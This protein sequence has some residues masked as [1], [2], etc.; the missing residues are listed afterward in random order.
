MAGIIVPARFPT[1]IIMK[2]ITFYIV[3]ATSVGCIAWSLRSHPIDSLM[4]KAEA[5]GPYT[6]ARPAVEDPLPVAGPKKI[7]SPELAP[8]A[9]DQIQP[10]LKA[11]RNG[12]RDA[13]LQIAK[14]MRSCPNYY[15]KDQSRMSLDETIS[16]Y[17]ATGIGAEEIRHNFERC[18]RIWASAD[19]G[20]SGEWL[21][22][23]TKAKQA[24]AMALTAEDLLWKAHS[25]VLFRNAPPGSNP[26]PVVT[27]PALDTTLDPRKL[28][29]EAAHSNNP[30]VYNVISHLSL[31]LFAG[32]PDAH[33]L[34]Y[35]WML[36]AC[37]RGLDCGKNSDLAASLCSH[38][39]GACDNFKDPTDYPLWLATNSK[40]DLSLVE[41]RAAEIIAK[42]DAGEYDELGLGS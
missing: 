35:S 5:V 32:N 34:Y 18:S 20:T 4:A 16:S 36:V 11:G 2:Q 1:G 38:S 40:V 9:F 25:E 30:D 13:Q 17:Q 12:D 37:Q 8:D 6:P 27:D 39:A 3:V 26:E 15:R 19:L 7:T 23:A 33:A 42:L 31:L 24:Q 14:I 10:L 28:L 41:T 21:A 22:M 29:L